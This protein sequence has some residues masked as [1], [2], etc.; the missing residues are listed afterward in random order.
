MYAITS[1]VPI[2]H[3]TATAAAF[4]ECMRKLKRVTA[5]DARLYSALRKYRGIS[6]SPTSFHAF[7]VVWDRCGRPDLEHTDMPHGMT[8]TFY[9]SLPGEE[10]NRPASAAW[11]QYADYID[12]TD[13]FITNE[14][15]P[16]T[17][18]QY[19]SWLA[20]AGRKNNAFVAEGD[21]DVAVAVHVAV[22]CAK[23]VEK[24]ENWW[25]FAFVLDTLFHNKALVH[26][27]A[28]ISAVHTHAEDSVV[29]R[30][31]LR[32]ECSLR[33]VFIRACVDLVVDNSND[34]ALLKR[35]KYM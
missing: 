17:V 23:E 29:L 2:D 31:Y 6:T 3:D 8:W 12:I 35:T 15:S 9:E 14:D 24:G 10:D 7:A 33:S 30:P 25:C 27:R 11:L 28:F 26:N 18:A 32:Y 21:V 34:A 13:N 22:R 4:V 16:A 5:G 20:V 1:S 19:L